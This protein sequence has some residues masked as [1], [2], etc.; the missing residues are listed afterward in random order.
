MPNKHQILLIVQE[1]HDVAHHG[2]EWTLSLL[3]SKYWI[4]R[5]R[6]LIKS[7]KSACITYRKLFAKPCEQRIADLPKERVTPN[8]APFTFV[9]MDCFGSFA[10]K[11]L[12][13]EKIWDNITS[14]TTRAVHIEKI[15]SLNTDS[16]LNALRRIISRRGCP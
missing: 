2:V 6:I 4:A 3:R 5:A 12:H 10:V 14:M 7:V 9:G 8:Q 11:S 13:S 16:F 15:D 1:L